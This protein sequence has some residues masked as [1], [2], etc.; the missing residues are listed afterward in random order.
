MKT[1]L[2]I[3]FLLAKVEEKS[4]KERKV[5]GGTYKALFYFKDIPDYF[6]VYG[7]GLVQA[8]GKDDN[9][10]Y[11]K[12]WEKSSFGSS[13]PEK[14]LEQLGSQIKTIQIM[15][16][17]NNYEKNFSSFRSFLNWIE[18]TPEKFGITNLPQETDPAKNSVKDSAVTEAK[19]A[20]NKE[21]NLEAVE[22]VPTENKEENQNLI[23]EEKKIENKI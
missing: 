2:N 6:Q 16:C 8:A 23:N 1:K 9:H 15:G 10:S 22:K 11:F 14:I 20:E 18:L 17:G 5:F 19:P 7:N 13:S 3:K 12:S 21:N 4:S